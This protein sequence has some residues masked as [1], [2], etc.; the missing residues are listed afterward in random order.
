MM[1]SGKFSNKLDP[2]VYMPTCIEAVAVMQAAARLGIIHA[3]VFAG[4]S[5]GALRQVSSA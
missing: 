2:V 1:N 3:V 5:H 4:F